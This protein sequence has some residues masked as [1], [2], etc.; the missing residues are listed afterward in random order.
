MCRTVQCVRMCLHR[1]ITYLMYQKIAIPCSTRPLHATC[2]L[3]WLQ[4]VSPSPSSSPHSVSSACQ[5][6]LCVPST[7]VLDAAEGRGWGHAHAEC[8]QREVT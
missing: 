5:L 7:S 6:Q 1:Y 2:E 3:V 4:V 8:S